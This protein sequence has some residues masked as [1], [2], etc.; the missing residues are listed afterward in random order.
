MN[1]R[2]ILL[3]SF[4]L[5]TLTACGSQSANSPEAVPTIVLESGNEAAMVAPSLGGVA[6]SGVVIPAQEASM[7]FALGGIVETVNV[8]VGDRVQAGDLLVELD[9][10]TIKLDL[11]QAERN[12]RE[13][14]SPSAIAQASQVVANAR[15]ALE[16]AQEKAEGLT[17]KR[18]SDTV[19]DNTQGEIDL[20]R[21]AL[22]RAADTYRLVE[23]R[24]DGDARKAAAL[25]ALT[26]AQMRLN[27][28][29]AKYN[30]LSGSPTETDAALIRANLETAQARFQEAQWYLLALK[31][32][33]VPAE[34]TG[35]GLSTL[36][37]ARDAIVAAQ[38]RLEAT[39]LVAP[40]AGMVISVNVT[41]G[42]YAV[43]A[44]PLVA[45]S[46][47]EN[48]LV[49]TTD[50]SERD[51]PKVEVGQPVSVFVEALNQN[52]TG[53]VTL[54]SP[55]SNTLGGDV[56]Y[57]TTIALDQPFPDGLRAGMTVNVQFG[58]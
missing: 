12:L 9:N 26:S 2:T 23:R 43:P 32:E 14:T 53:Q 27:D 15:K 47:I 19:L 40:I 24:P 37:S 50:L 48:L 46:D 1:Y 36:Q 8:K 7:A 57:K 33:T 30:Y 51:V 4:V 56:V 18:A 5:L 6:A 42:E 38:Q 22:A 31:G 35:V 29:I 16:E 55:V 17:Y 54:I 13:L 3:V 52:I 10:T 34:A 25:V 20:A 44:S 41:A 58:E 21:Q 28:L 11:A 45:I 49:E 39:R